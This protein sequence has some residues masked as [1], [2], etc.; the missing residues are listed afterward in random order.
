MKN[1]FCVLPWIHLATHPN[2]EVSL[3][4][5]VDNSSNGLAHN[6]KL[7]QKKRLNLNENSIENILN[8]D[9]FKDVRL[10]MLDGKIP[11]ACKGCFHIFT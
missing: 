10:K 11:D 9:S 3:C 6:N 8:S 5:E 1:T 7:N 2:G 4:C